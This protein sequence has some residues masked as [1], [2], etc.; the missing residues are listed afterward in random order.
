[1]IQYGMR[2]ML[3]F[4]A[5]I[6]LLSCNSKNLV[7]ASSDILTQKNNL[8]QLAALMPGVFRNDRQYKQDPDNFYHSQMALSRI[9]ADR[10]DGKWFYVEQALVGALESPYRQRVYRLVRGE[11]DTLISR[12]Y[13]LPNSKAATGKTNDLDFWETINPNELD[14]RKGCAVYLT[15]R[16]KKAQYVGGTRPNGCLSSLRGVTVFTSQVSI[17]WRAV[18]CWDRG[19]DVKGRAIWGP[20]K[21]YVFE[22]TTDKIPRNLLPG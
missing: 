14:E 13:T 9:W 17:Q 21:A 12:V 15:K 16:G 11:R 20:P 22:R 6:C 4:G 19:F 1:M 8:E 5:L 3:I 10:D 18:M 2:W 7:T